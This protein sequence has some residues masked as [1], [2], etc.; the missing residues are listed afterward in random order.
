MPGSTEAVPSQLAY[1]LTTDVHGNYN[2]G[3]PADHKP[4]TP[5]VMGQVY[6]TFPNFKS[7]LEASWK[8]P[9]GPAYDSTYMI[10]DNIDSEIQAKIHACANP[11]DGAEVA[12]AVSSSRSLEGNVRHYVSTLEYQITG[13]SRA[14][15]RM[16]MIKPPGFS[17]APDWLR[18][19]AMLYARNAFRQEQ[20]LRNR[21]GAVGKAAAD[22][23]AKGQGKG[24][25]GKGKGKG[26]PQP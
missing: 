16:R 15:D 10:V 24:K 12:R 23:P 8:G 13:D 21:P 5:Y 26:K 7:H 17:L 2:S 14:A 25:K 6:Q 9:R 3:L 11:G 22:Q 1:A 4:I 18:D 20:Q 19:D